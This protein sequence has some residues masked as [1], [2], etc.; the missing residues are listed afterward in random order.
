MT[1]PFAQGDLDRMVTESRTT[2]EDQRGTD[3]RDHAR[4]E[5]RSD[6]PTH[7]P[8]VGQEKL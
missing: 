8:Q 3:R 1:G 5:R 7:G 2:S 6:C 4:G